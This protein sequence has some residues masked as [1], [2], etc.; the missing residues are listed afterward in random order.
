MEHIRRGASDLGPSV[1]SDH[2]NRA[3]SFGLSFGAEC[4]LSL[5][6]RFSLRAGE[7][8]PISA[9]CRRGHAIAQRGDAA[10][11]RPI[12]AITSSLTG[13]RYFA[14][15]RASVSMSS[16]I[17]IA[18]STRGSAS[19]SRSSSSRPLASSRYG[20]SRNIRSALVTCECVSVYSG[21]ISL[22]R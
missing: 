15:S 18:F 14:W 8:R 2:G 21:R 11:S 5:C 16:L 4:F 3:Y 9:N 17:T 13:S 10:S 22:L 1:G 6:G 7:Y 12:S 20:V 19:R